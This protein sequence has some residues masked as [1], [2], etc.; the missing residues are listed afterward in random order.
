MIFYDFYDKTENV[1]KLL[2]RVAFVGCNALQRFPEWDQSCNIFFSQLTCRGRG[3]AQQGS[4]HLWEVVD[5]D[6]G[7]GGSSSEDSSPGDGDS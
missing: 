6:L 1:L 5:P 2:R 7:T 4:G 3:H